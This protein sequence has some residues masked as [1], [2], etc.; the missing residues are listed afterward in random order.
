MGPFLI[1]RGLLAG[2]NSPLLFF[3]FLTPLHHLLV[4]LREGLI[5]CHACAFCACA[6]GDEAFVRQD[7]T[8]S[9]EAYTASLRHDTGSAA[10]WA[11]RAAAY[12]RL[13]EWPRIAH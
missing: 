9:A 11:N 6:Q 10:V 8:A 4:P 7:Y 2:V 5:V 12:L 3:S 13:G 1:A